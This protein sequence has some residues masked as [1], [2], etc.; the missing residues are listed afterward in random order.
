[1]MSCLRE[2]ARL[3]SAHATRRPST[4]SSIG[5]R[6]ELGQV[7]RV[8]RLRK[9]GRAD[10]LGVVLGVDRTAPDRRSRRAGRHVAA[11]VA[12]TAAAAAIAVAMCAVRRCR[13]ALVAGC[14]RLRNPSRLPEIAL[15]RQ[16]AVQ[17][18][19]SW[20]FDTAP[21]FWAS[22]VPFLNRISVGMPRMPN[23]GGVCGFSS[24][25]SFAILTRPWYSRGDLV[26]D[27]GDHLAGSA[28][29][30]PEIEQD[31]FGRT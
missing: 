31:G 1:M 28:P 7:H 21:T 27:R 18:G 14:G 26:E 13:A 17:E 22:T 20:D 16:V 6:L 15:A 24:M 3:S 2:R 9:L 25:L 8:A 4:S 10:D 5:L 12:A 29:L 23:F 11:C 30:G 19:D